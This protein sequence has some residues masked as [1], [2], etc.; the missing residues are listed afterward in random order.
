MGERKPSQFLRQFKILTPDVPGDFLRSMWCSRLPPDV[1]AILA[2]QP[3]GD[4]SAAGRCADRII[5]AATHAALAS[6]ERTS[7][8]YQH[9]SRQ[10]TELSAEMAI[11]AT[12]PGISAAATGNNDW[13]TDLVPERTLHPPTNGCA[14]TKLYSALLLPPVKKTNSGHQ[15]RQVC[16]TAT[17]RLFV[18]DNISK[19]RF[20]V[21]TG[22]GLCVYPRRLI[23]RR[24]KRVKYDL[25]A[26]NGTDVPTYGWLRLRLNLG[27]GRDFTWRFVVADITHPLIDINFLSFRPPVSETLCFLFSRIPDDEKSPKPNNSVYSMLVN[28]GAYY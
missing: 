8:A 25:R 24:K 12:A 9:F 27:L 20:L 28:D 22:S 23:P 4:L 14:D 6:V 19:R 18:M 26:P 13:A 16:S 3:E 2:G 10:M 11:I 17:G 7:A 21:D 15:R 5:R 1:R